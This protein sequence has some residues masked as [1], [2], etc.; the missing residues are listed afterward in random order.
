MKIGYARCSSDSQEYQLQVDQLKALGCEK[1]FAEKVSGKSTNNRDQLQACIDYAREGDLVCCTKLD[2]LAR[3][4]IDALKIA[5]ALQAKGV[6]LHLEDLKVDVNSDVG[7]LVYTTIAAVAEMERKRIAERTREGREVAKAKGT[8]M[9]RPVSIDAQKVLQ[10]K[11]EGLGATAIAK[12]LKIG[13][14]S[15]YRILDAN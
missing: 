2:R 12:Q 14:A 1:I 9:G 7:R 13:R 11:S 4:T 10:L 3:N 5:D 8:H 6:G 15:V